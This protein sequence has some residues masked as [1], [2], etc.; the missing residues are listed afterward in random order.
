[1]AEKDNKGFENSAKSWICDYAYFD[2]DVKVRGYCLVT[3]KWRGSAQ[4]DYNINVKL[5]H[6][7]PVVFHNLINYDSHLVMEELIKFNLKMNFIPN[8]LEKSMSFSINNK[9]SF[10]ESFWFQSS[11]LD[12]L[13]KNLSKNDFK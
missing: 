2:G 6:K 13:V 11:S 9:L 8:G 5:N 1:M 12:S 7:I 4:R 10:I 3:G